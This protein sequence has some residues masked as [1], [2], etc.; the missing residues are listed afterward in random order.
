MIDQFLAKSVMEVEITSLSE[1]NSFLE[2]HAS[3]IFD[4]YK[5][6]KFVLGYPLGMGAEKGAD[7]NSELYPLYQIYGIA[8]V[9]DSYLGVGRKISS[10]ID[11]DMWKLK[12]AVHRRL[13]IKYAVSNDI[14]ATTLDI[15]NHLTNDN[16]QK[17]AG[18]AIDDNNKLLILTSVLPSEMKNVKLEKVEET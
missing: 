11:M 7:V 1:L 17:V 5:K 13:P 4:K 8:H 6:Y 9:D 18:I 2:T 12:Y 15:K 16:I 3:K 14:L 10:T